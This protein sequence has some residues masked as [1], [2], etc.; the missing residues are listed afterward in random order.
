MEFDEISIPG[1]LFAVIAFAVGIIVSK[2]MGSD[3]IWR[4]AAGFICAI[5]GYFIGGKIAE[6]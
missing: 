4:L 1:M 3:I 2:S 6:G 5:A